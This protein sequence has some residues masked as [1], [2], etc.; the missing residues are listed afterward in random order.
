MGLELDEPLL[1]SP[2]GLL[3]ELLSL[4]PGLFGLLTEP[5]VGLEGVSI[6]FCD[7]FEVGTL[8]VVLELFS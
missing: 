6:G 2:F 5:L 1:F 3:T 8:A 7:G 4:S